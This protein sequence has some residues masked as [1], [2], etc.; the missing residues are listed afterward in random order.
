MLIISSSIILEL[1]ILQ[2]SNN[3]IYLIIDINLLRLHHTIT[4]LHIKK[5]NWSIIYYSI[6]KKDGKLRL[7]HS[8][9]KNNNGLHCNHIK[10]LCHPMCLSPVQKKRTIILSYSRHIHCNIQFYVPSMLSCWLSFVS[11]K[12]AMAKTG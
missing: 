2:Y 5:Y 10:C 1:H 9:I 6:H 11:V 3:I 12:T 7:S 4:S 8:S